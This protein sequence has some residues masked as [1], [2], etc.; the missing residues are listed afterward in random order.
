MVG[1][2]VCPSPK[3]EGLF[4]LRGLAYEKDRILY[5]KRQIF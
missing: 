5:H 3:G 4:T 2:K 1:L